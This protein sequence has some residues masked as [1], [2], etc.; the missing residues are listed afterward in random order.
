[1]FILFVLLIL[2]VTIV[3]CKSHAE[4]NCRREKFQLVTCGIFRRQNYPPLAALPHVG[5]FI[6][7]TSAKPFLG[8]D[9][10]LWIYHLWHVGNFITHSWLC[11]SW[12]NSPSPILLSVWLGHF[13]THAPCGI[14]SNPHVKSTVFTH[15]L[16]H[17]F[18]YFVV[19][20]NTFSELPNNFLCLWPP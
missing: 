16:W 4:K 9:F 10:A 15:A 18:T 8:N 7:T 6:F 17:T 11:H 2:L 19:L 13:I 5:E 14:C 20:L 1:M 12:V 3:K